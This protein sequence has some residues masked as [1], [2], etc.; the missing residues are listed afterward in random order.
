[1]KTKHKFIYIYLIW[2][3]ALLP[4]MIL[5]DYTPNNELRYLNIVDEALQSGNIFTFTNQGEIYADK[6]PL[7]FWFMMLG[8]LIFGK[9]YMW[10]YSLLSFI[11]AVIIMNTMS[12]WIRRENEINAQNEVNAQDKIVNEDENYDKVNK[13][14]KITAPLMLMTAG[15]FAVVAVI[16]RM[17]MLMNMFIVLS[18]YSFY[19]MYS[20]KNIKLNSY[21]FPINVFLALFSKG[22]LGLLIPFVSS[23]LFL[24]YKKRM[25]DYKLYWGWR[26]LFII[27]TGC[28][29]WFTGVYIEGG[30]DYL[31]N[32]LVHQTVGRGIDSFHHKEP[33]YYYLISIWYTLAPWSFLVIGLFIVG[34]VRKKINSTLEQFF[35]VIILSTLVTL[36]VISSKLSIYSLPVVPFFIFLVAMLFNKFD[37]QNRWVKLSIA[38]PAIIF[39]LAIPVI[40][41][42]S[43]TDEMRYLANPF[44]YAGAFVLSLTGIITTYYLYLRRN[45]IRSINSLAAGFLLT[46]F[47]VG[48]SLPQLNSRLGWGMMC[49]KVLELSEKYNISDYWVYNIKRS[50]NMD[51]YLGKDVAKV[52]KNDLLK[53]TVTSE[54]KLLMINVKNINIDPDISSLVKNKE[55]YQ[56]GEHLIVVF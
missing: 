14:N 20:G 18:L 52:D 12:K 45:T 46:L 42:I 8:K 10:Y 33:F 28:I 9:H 56:V 3:I 40:I 55:Q 39:I 24:I 34:I 21:I 19:Q 27:L 4:I 50:E 23:V 47:V 41:Y 2:L 1:M 53:V 13:H 29:V 25:S 51:V 35:V 7:H 43:K 17:D 11:P 15:L 37:M 5:R 16:V 31:N 26:S 38:I 49:K 30:N 32:L 22:P 48:W 54:N 6:P 44:I 36:S